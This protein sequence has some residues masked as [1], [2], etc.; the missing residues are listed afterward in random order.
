[1]VGFGIPEGSDGG[2]VD[3]QVVACVLV[4]GVVADEVIEVAVLA[5]VAIAGAAGGAV[6]GSGCGH[7]GE[8]GGIAETQGAGGDAGAEIGHV[9]NIARSTSRIGNGDCSLG[10]LKSQQAQQHNNCCNGFG[11][12]VLF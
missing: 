8:A 11:I 7:A 9:G 2:C 10:I 12:H 6:G 5:A 1:M 4:V 3:E